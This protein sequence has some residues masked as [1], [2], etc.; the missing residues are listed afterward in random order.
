[1]IMIMIMI[2]II[3]IKI[4]IQRSIHYLSMALYI[5]KKIFNC[6]KSLKF[7]VNYINKLKII[8]KLKIQKACLK[9]YVFEYSPRVF[10]AFF[11]KN[12]LLNASNQPRF[13]LK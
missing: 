4:F 5:K 10:W 9:R 13:I 7:Y 12:L 3:I 1:M 6:L 2:I 11:V 8:K